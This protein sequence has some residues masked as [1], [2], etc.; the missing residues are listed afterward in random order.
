MRM[1]LYKVTEA[2]ASNLI[3]YTNKACGGVYYAMVTLSSVATHTVIMLGQ[4]FIY[5]HVAHL[6]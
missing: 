4:T 6:T 2:L 5:N 1:F 3:F